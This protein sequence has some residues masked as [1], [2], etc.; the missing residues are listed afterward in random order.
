MSTLEQQYLALERQLILSRLAGGLPEEQEDQLVLRLRKIWG[1]T[2]PARQRRLD[3]DFSDRLVPLLK[4][5]FQVQK[6]AKPKKE[7]TMTKFS[8]TSKGAR[9]SLSEGKLGRLRQQVLE[10]VR[11]HQAQGA[12]CYEAEVGLRL[13]HQTTS[14]RC[15]ELLKAGLI[16]DSGERR[17][18]G[19]G[20]S[21]RVYLAK[22]AR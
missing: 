21:A 3:N 11:H 20:R 12:T 5:Q 15:T 16:W 1:A 8:D 14:A 17:A 10:F 7:A 6:R 18:T 9:D 4:K 19:S 2:S 22:S 13:S